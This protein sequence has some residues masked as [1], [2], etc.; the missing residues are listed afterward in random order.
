MYLFTR[1]VRVQ[2]GN[3]RDSMEWAIG[4]TEQ[5]NQI[6]ELRTSLYMRMF[7]PGAGTLTWAG[8]AADITELETAMDKLA[9]DSRFVAAA[10][11]GAVTTVDGA[12]D[13]LFTLIHGEPE[14]DRS[15]EYVSTVQAV[16]AVGHLE[17]GVRVGME[18]AQLA[19]EIT[20]TPTMFVA[21]VT[22]PYGNVGWV[23]GFERVQTLEAGQLALMADP[24]WLDLLDREAG[25]AYMSEP[26]RTQQIIHRRIA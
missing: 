23:S 4:I 11:M 3:A 9:L 2:P 1:T 16:C 8:F 22:G 21:G 20:G 17:H 10:D 13:G 24:R 26:A 18:I 14:A 6:T 19:E 7:S 12:D 5:V 25:T 15:I